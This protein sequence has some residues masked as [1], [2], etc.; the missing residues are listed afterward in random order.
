MSDHPTREC[1]EEF[2]HDVIEDPAPIG[3]HLSACTP[4]AAV[5]EDFRREGAALSEL[6]SPKTA[7]VRRREWRWAAAA[8]VGVAVAVFFLGGRPARPA[9]AEVRGDVRHLRPDGIRLARPGDAIFPGQGLVASGPGSVA[10]V[11]FADSTTLE[12]RDGGALD[13]ISGRRVTLARGWIRV[14]AEDEIF[15]RTA[16]AEVSARGTTFAVAAFAERTRVEVEAGTLRVT[17]RADE[18]SVDVGEGG[19]AEVSAGAPLVPK[20]N[21]VVAPLPDRPA[22]YDLL[23]V[24]ATRPVDPP[25]GRAY[26]QDDPDRRKI[27]SVLFD[28]GL[29]FETEHP[30][31]YFKAIVKYKKAHA[32]ALNEGNLEFVVGSLVR[33]GLCREALGNVDEAQEAYRA[34]CALPA[35]PR[36]TPIAREKLLLR[37][38]DVALDRLAAATKAWRD[39]AA[40][41]PH[42]LEEAR[43]AA[44]EKIRPLDAGAVPGLIRG[45]E[46]A[47][48][49]VRDFAADR[50]AEVADAAAVSA[51]AARLNRS[52]AAAALEK[53]LQKHAQASEFDRLADALEP[54]R[55][56]PRVA[57]RII[58]LRR[59]GHEARGRLPASL[60]D[61]ETERALASVLSDTG[62]GADA[63][64]AAARAAGAIVG[65][66]GTLVDALLGGFSGPREV[67]EACCRAAG[68]ADP[69]SGV[70]VRRLAEA[71][72]RVVRHEP[73]KAGAGWDNDATV[74]HA[75]AEAL[76]RMGLVG[77][78]SALVEAL[79]DNDSRVRAAAHA[80]LREITG[81]DF[82]YEADRPREERL[83]AQTRWRGW[84]EGTG[85]VD[86]IVERFRA[87][88]AS[89]NRGSAETLFDSDGPGRRRKERFVEDAVELGPATFDRLVPFLSDAAPAVR[90]FA[91]EGC[92]RL[93]AGRLRDIFDRD[94]APVARTSAALGL[95]SL[96]AD[97]IGAAER[98]ALRRGL[99]AGSAEVREAGAWALGRV[100]DAS[101]GADLV[102]AANDADVRV[103]RAALRAILRLGLRD[104][105]VEELATGAADAR[106]RQLAVEILG[107]SE[108]RDRLRPVI[109]ARQDPRLEVRDAAAAAV[110]KLATG[111]R[112]LSLLRDEREKAT[113]RAGAAL[114]IGDLGEPG[115][116]PSLAGQLG[117]PDPEVRL[118]ICRTLAFLKPRSVKVL[119]ALVRTMSNEDEREAVR[120]GAFE[121]LRA[122]AGVDGPLFRASDPKSARDASLRHWCKW[123]HENR[124]ALPD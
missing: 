101:A 80:A 39:T 22:E 104:A 124:S 111:D 45:L 100:G 19:Y 57:E 79:D 72:R 123:L 117:D 88:A 4:C 97:R 53:I 91:A 31:D 38:V 32:A 108:D 75:A 7:S 43:A 107:A 95:G 36:W 116:A 87:F 41:S 50:L 119:E 90:R 56:L 47:D 93:E 24:P 30:R 122:T 2:A 114:A 63:R 27:A 71:L 60:A 86:V 103:Q 85:G 26:P 5:V 78:S 62:V 118:S 49:V 37:G 16:G 23:L 66:S 21:V 33:L 110:R 28:E 13:R 68:S 8:I 82:G 14:R 69:G 42:G 96:P 3:R 76:G 109:H 29:R 106:V 92:A 98:D 67:R 18:R 64:R 105:R 9:L 121:A 15:V 51:L 44:W 55:E 48:D 6:L 113:V 59:R 102:R 46:H 73:E 84:W 74:R 83:E 65:I 54:E 52:G 17:R 89:W 61:A 40:R 77:S 25:A 10:F 35:V 81:N 11:T 20:E 58:D 94:A 1:L 120:D 112:L 70:D 12:L 34:A 115:P 99:A